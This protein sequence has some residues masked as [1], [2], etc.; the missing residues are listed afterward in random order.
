MFTAMDENIT[1]RFLWHLLVLIIL[2][3]LVSC[4]DN[5]AVAGENGIRIKAGE[6][7][8]QNDEGSYMIQFNIVSSADV[9]ANIALLTYTYPC[10]ETYFSVFV[11][12]PIKIEINNSAFEMKVGQ[13]NLTGKFIDSTHA[14]GTWEVF[15][16]QNVFLGIVCP[17]AK[18]TW[19][20]SSK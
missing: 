6:W 18:G 1:R 12:K 5:T 15:T 2:S 10:G 20:G 7:I 17:A 8:G 9:G 16:H 13:T 14:E 4:S 19:K 3:I 11:P